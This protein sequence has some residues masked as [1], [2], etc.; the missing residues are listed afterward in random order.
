MALVNK[1]QSQPQRINILFL[2]KDRHEGAE[3]NF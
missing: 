2:N 1:T 3:V